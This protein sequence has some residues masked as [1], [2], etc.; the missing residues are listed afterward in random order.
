MPARPTILVSGRGVKMLDVERYGAC[1]ASHAEA[2]EVLRAADGAA[3]DA[4][5]ASRRSAVMR[6]ATMSCVFGVGVALGRADLASPRA[7]ARAAPSAPSP[8]AL[9][10]VPAGDRDNS[11][12]QGLDCGDPDISA[13]GAEACAYYYQRGVEAYVSA[14]S[15]AVSGLT[16]LSSDIYCCGGEC[17]ANWDCFDWFCECVPSE[18]AAQEFPGTVCTEDSLLFAGREYGY[19]ADELGLDDALGHADGAHP[20]CVCD[21][22]PSFADGAAQCHCPSCTWVGEVERDEDDEYDT[23]WS[24]YNPA[25]LRQTSA[26]FCEVGFTL[27]CTTMLTGANDNHGS[28]QAPDVYNKDCPQNSVS[29]ILNLTAAITPKNIDG[30]WQL[31]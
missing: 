22:G 27:K 7:R 14:E 31:S 12:L 2:V 8:P 10:R 16:S 24:K 13:A 5:R 15:K 30:P 28:S 3:E 23:V 6:V 25:D 29:Q 1:P 18:T 21:V 20:L 4:R 11:A 26:C 17:M 9:L 19:E